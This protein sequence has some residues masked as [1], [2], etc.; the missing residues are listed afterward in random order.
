MNKRIGIITYHRADNFGAMLQCYALQEILRIIGYDAMVIDYRQP[1]TEL[2]YSP[3]RLDIVKRGLVAPR[4]LGGYLFKV[5]PTLYKRRKLY[6][7]FRK[8]TS[9]LYKTS[10]NGARYAARYQCLSYRL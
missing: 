9:S 8:K 7:R 10:K 1:F 5:L 2:I 3:W 6:D 4:L